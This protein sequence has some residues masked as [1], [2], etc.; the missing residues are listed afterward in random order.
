MGRLERVDFDK[1]A[2]LTQMPTVGATWDL[3]LKQYESTKEDAYGWD[4]RLDDFLDLVRAASRP[5]RISVSFHGAAS[6]ALP[7]MVA[8]I[9]SIL[10]EFE[11]SRYMWAEGLGLPQFIAQ[12]KH[13]DAFLYEVGSFLCVVCA[14]SGI[15]RHFPGEDEGRVTTEGFL[16]TFAVQVFLMVTSNLFRTS[17]YHFDA[18]HGVG[19]LVLFGWSL[20]STYMAFKQMRA[21]I[22]GPIKD[23]RLGD[24]PMRVFAGATTGF[25]AGFPLG[26]TITYL[27]TDPAI[28]NA[29]IHPISDWEALNMNGNF[30]PLSLNLFTSFLLTS[31]KFKWAPEVVVIPLA[32]AILFFSYY[33]PFFA[34]VAPE[35]QPLLAFLTTNPI[36]LSWFVLC[37]LTFGHAL[38]CLASRGEAHVDEEE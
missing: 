23:I 29:A 11:G 34:L 24:R 10:F 30:F 22:V 28:V 2:Q 4:R 15:L 27:L 31:M 36:F 7:V 16:A 9:G 38:F 21:L 17:G 35:F 13:V 3:Y 14:V 18:Y 37:A 20:L 1:L 6:V 32:F 12:E 26:S 8:Y 25:G 19:F 5:R 33:D